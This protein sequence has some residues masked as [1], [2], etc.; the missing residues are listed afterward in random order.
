MEKQ[1]TLSI[2]VLSYNNEQYI[3]DCL[4]SIERQNV[5]E[6]EVY[7][8]DDS[9]TD[10]SVEVIESFIKDKPQFHLIEKE[11]SGGAISSQIGIKMAKGKYLAIVDSDDIVADGAYKTLIGRIEDD[12]S[13]FAAGLPVRLT[14]SFMFANLA[15]PS[16]KNLFVENRVLSSEDDIAEFSKQ[17]FYW[18]AVYKMKFIKENQIEMPGNLLIADRY[19]LYKAVINAKK[20]SLDSSIVYYWRKKGNSEKL[21]LTD[22][23]A[24]YHMISDRCDSFQAQMK[25][26]VQD[27]LKNGKCN[28]A[29]WENSI[30]RIYYPLYGLTDEEAEYGYEEFEKACERYRFFLMQ[31]RGFFEHLIINSKIPLKTKYFTETILAKNYKELYDFL[32]EKKDFLDLDIKKLDQN[33]L[34]AIVKECSTLF[35]VKIKE[36]DGKIFLYIQCGAELEKQHDFSVEKVMVNNRFFNH[37]EIILP[38]DKEENRIDI[39]NLAPTTYIV[40]T[41]CNHG[42]EKSYYEIR[43]VEELAQKLSVDIGDKRIMYNPTLSM[44]SIYQKNRFTLLEKDGCF[45]LSVNDDGVKDMFFFNINHNKRTRIEKKDGFYILKKDYFLKGINILMY[46]NKQGFYSMVSKNELSNENLRQK[47]F[48]TLFNKARIEVELDS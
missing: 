3:N 35:P 7:I 20:I 4:S 11:N 19:F 9:S 6:Y 28:K 40:N 15:T 8:I 47:P 36:D 30:S 18:N 17:G 29:I 37:E 25:L 32:V 2:V 13:E 45:Y 1:V 34:K 33:I 5:D 16:E 48:A 41:I 43:I 21:S 14:N 46:C 44:L 42:G 38:F 26:C 23:M 39:S 22:Q 12:D 31:Y 27:A 24:E 10:K